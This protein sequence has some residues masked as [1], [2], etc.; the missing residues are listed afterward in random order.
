M[1]LISSSISVALILVVIVVFVVVIFLEFSGPIIEVRILL[2]L[3][4]LGRLPGHG[5]W[6][7]LLHI[8]LLSA[9]HVGVLAVLLGT[10]RV[11]QG[12]R[13]WSLCGSRHWL[14]HLAHKVVLLTMVVLLVLVAVVLVASTSRVILVWVVLVS[15]A[16]R[17]EGRV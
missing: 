9:S 2:L 10:T 3:L 1:W 8:G 4:V 15:I 5:W 6:H 13:H 14:R 12:G 16:R 17:S 11:H 7:S